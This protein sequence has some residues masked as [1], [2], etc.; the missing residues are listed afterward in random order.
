MNGKAD[1]DAAA[2]RR[3]DRGVDPDKL[4]VEVQQR[5]AGIA[6][7]NRGVGLNEILQ[8]FKVQAAAAKGRDNAG[9]GGLAKAERVADG[10]GEV[11]DAKFIRVSN[12]DLRQVVWLNQ[13]QQ[14]DIALFIAPDQFGIELTAIVQ[15]DADLLRLIDDVVIGQHIA[16]RRVDD[17]AGAEPFKRLRLLLR[18]VIAK[19]FFSSSGILSVGEAVPST[20]TLTTAGRTFSSIGA[21][22]GNA[23]WPGT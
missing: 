6:A 15:L 18:G 23:P 8:P 1:A 10:D 22:L 2:A 13:L 11:A 19:I 17:N 3:E 21:R 14:S 5:A 20:C 12:G 7:V 4:A 16:F 9:C